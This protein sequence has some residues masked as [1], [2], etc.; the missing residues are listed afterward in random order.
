MTSYLTGFAAVVYVMAPIVFLVSGIFP[1]HCDSIAFFVYFMPFFLCCQAL[2]VL[3]GN[4]AKGLWRGQ[5]MSFALF[6]TW[7]KATVAGGAAAL[8]NKKPTFAVTHKTKQASGA[9]LRHVIPQLVAMLALML[10]GAYG[11][12]QAAA[13][14]RPLFASVITLLW[15]LVDLALLASMVR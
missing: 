6:P 11:A 10:A 14:N 7:I 15:V 4:V 1:I 2:F 9:G 8:F 13:G 3:S 5:Q 12:I